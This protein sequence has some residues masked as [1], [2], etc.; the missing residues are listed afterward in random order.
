MPPLILSRYRSG[1]GPSLSPEAQFSAL[2]LE[3]NPLYYWKLDD[4]DFETELVDLGSEAT[5]ASSPDAAGALERQEGPLG[6]GSFSAEFPGNAD[7]ELPLGTNLL[8]GGTE[9]AFLCFIK[10]N[11]GQNYSGF[12]N[13]FA[14]QYTSF[15]RPFFKISIAGGGDPNNYYI[16]YQIATS[17]GSSSSNSAQT[18]TDLA[19]EEWHLIIINHDGINNPDIWADGVLEENLSITRDPE[20]WIADIDRDTPFENYI[21]G[22]NSIDGFLAH[23]AFFPDVL[24]E[25]TIA[26]LNSIFQ[27][28]A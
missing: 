15:S 13:I 3:N 12:P 7:L 23:V 18:N 17:T 4:E 5:T 19:E 10:V 24:S 28:A 21:A 6:E 11:A 2:V 27:S 16:M 22:T 14:S 26:Q 9:G 25:E 1:S 20:V 8:A